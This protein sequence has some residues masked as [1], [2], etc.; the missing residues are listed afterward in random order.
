M[1][2][3]SD[4]LGSE[5]A[6][7]PASKLALFFILIFLTLIVRSVVLHILNKRVAEFVK[8]TET[9]LDDLLLNAIINPLGY[10]ILLQGFYIAIISLGLPEKIGLFDISKLVNNLYLFAFTFILLYFAFRIIDVI[11]Y[12]IQEK[13]KQTESAL[14]DQIAP[15]FVKSLR[16]LVV[17]M[18]VLFILNNF[19]YSVT[20][21]LTGL[22]IGG[23]AFALA[24]QDTISNLFGSFT[25]FS[26]KP[27]KLGD[28]ISIGDLEGTVEEVGFRSTR[29]RRF[30]QALVTLPNSQFI[31]SG[32]VNYSEM[33]KR[34]IKFDLGVTYGT[35]AGKI[36]QVVEGIKKIIEEEDR[37]DNS[38]YRVYFTDFGAYSLNILIQCYTRTT[39]GNE[40]L[41]IKEEFN[42]EIMQLLEELGVEIAFP[43]QTIYLEKT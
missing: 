38:F 3:L 34:R 31:K 32:V 8:K 39:N 7:V 10:F 28:W 23:L 18:G 11:G 43:S 2:T 40:H 19:G 6:G 26:D 22:G 29:I 42:L 17:T 9:E 27:F 33:K 24:A 20:S 15:L 37:F 14:D 16:V 30:D 36:T 21:L 1:I 12:F 13:A 5:I 41:K 35:S 25:V 4:I